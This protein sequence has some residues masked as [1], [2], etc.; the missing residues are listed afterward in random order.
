MLTHKS[1]VT[2]LGAVVLASALGTP[3]HG[4][5]NT[6]S[7]Y[8]TFSGPVSLPGVTLPAGT[9]VFEQVDV[10]TP[11]V[12]VVRSRAR[13]RVHF[14]GF[15][16]RIDRPANARPDQ[17][18]TFAETERGTAPRIQAWYPV[19]ETRGHAFSYPR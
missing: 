17:L 15:T 3:A 18:V 12:V 10:T 11:D 14:L 6:H 7:N 8:L 1:V 19:N 5:G 9:Y 4:K 2:A 13:D 16:T